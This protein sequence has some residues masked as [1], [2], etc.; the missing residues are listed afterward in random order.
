VNTT[1]LRFHFETK[2]LPLD[3]ANRPR[4]AYTLG[5]PQAIT[6][7]PLTTGQVANLLHVSEQTV[8]DWSA[9]GKLQPELSPG[10]HRRYDELAVRRLA[11]AERGVN[12]YWQA[13]VTLKQT[14]AGGIQLLDEEEQPYRKPRPESIQ[15][16]AYLHYHNGLEV[17]PRQ[18]ILT[19]APILQARDV[20]ETAPEVDGTLAA[21]TI[22][23]VS[24]LDEQTCVKMLTE[25]LP[26]TMAWFKH[27]AVP[28]TGVV[29]WQAPD[30]H[31]WPSM[32]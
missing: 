11:L 31:T 6:F 8:R 7:E 15:L 30:G 9:A 16:D 28:T 32:F 22:L 1:D 14:G 17:I 21:Y 13:A 10:G 5:M 29:R 19:G 20:I 25:Q 2:N 26:A 18:L 12:V 4:L 3:P 24:A 27:N 23:A